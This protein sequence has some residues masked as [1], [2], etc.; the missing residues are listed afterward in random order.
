MGNSSSSTE[1]SVS[2]ENVILHVY[3]SKDGANVPTLGFGVFHTG[4]E[5]YGAE[6][7]YDGGITASCG[8]TSQKPK[9]LPKDSPWKFKESIVSF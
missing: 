3:D 4:L 6:Y 7:V 5:V 9:W 8:I 2:G 1:S